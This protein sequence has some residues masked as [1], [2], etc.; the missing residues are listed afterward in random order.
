MKKKDVFRYG[1]EQF[2]DEVKDGPRGVTDHQIEDWLDS[3]QSMA[4]A[5]KTASDFNVQQDFYNKIRSCFNE[6]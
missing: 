2:F 6:N 3:V 5:L 4:A 1:M